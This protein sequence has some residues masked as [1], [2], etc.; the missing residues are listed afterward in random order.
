MILENNDIKGSLDNKL[1]TRLNTKLHIKNYIE[2]IIQIV[3]YIKVQ[4]ILSSI[5]KYEVTRQFTVL[6]VKNLKPG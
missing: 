4:V 3:Y 5:T 2:V 6:E 1:I